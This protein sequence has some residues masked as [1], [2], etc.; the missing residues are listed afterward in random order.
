MLTPVLMQK[1]RSDL[2]K[3]LFKPSSILQSPA[4]G[5][6]HL[7]GDIPAT[8]AAFLSEGENKGGVMIPPGAGPAVGADTRFSDFGQRAFDDRPEAVELLK[9]SA[10]DG[11]GG[12]F[13][14][15]VV[16]IYYYIHTVKRK[17][18]LFYSIMGSGGTG[19][20]PLRQKSNFAVPAPPAMLLSAQIDLRTPKVDIRLF[21]ERL[22][23]SDFI[24]EK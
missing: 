15:Y 11:L 6:D 8:A 16:Y 9:K 22:L 2:I 18:H 13:F 12:G 4:Q 23:K 7:G 10:M 20:A 24:H 5:A 14:V 17:N 3:Q 19:Q 21:S 1:S